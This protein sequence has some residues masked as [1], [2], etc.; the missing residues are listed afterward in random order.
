L[1]NNYPEEKKILIEKSLLELFPKEDN[2]SQ[3]IYKAMRHSLFPGGKRFRPV[4][5]LLTAEIL[6][7]DIRKILPTACATE[8]IHTYSLIHDDLPAIDN[9]NLRRGQPTCHI[10][11]GEDIAILAGDALFAE[12]FYLISSKQ[13]ADCSLKIIEVIKELSFASGV[14]G[15]VGGQVVD[16]EST[17][18]N[19][20]LSTLEFI[21][22][23]K[24]GRLI[25]AS[26][27]VASILA[28]ASEKETEA[29]SDYSDCL[30]LAFQITDDIL[31]T[32]GK[33][34]LLGKETGSDKRLFKSTYVSIFGLEKTKI[35][36]E[37][38]IEKAKA[39][40]DIFG[41]KKQP[42]IDIANFVYNR[43][44]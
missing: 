12:A 40:L 27:K 24:T 6:N 23:N 7:Y 14:R 29:L 11:F 15:M 25:S 42:L 44:S 41:E 17:G 3:T 19:I 28:G 39:S 2:Y 1:K 26:I 43:D 5:S 34:E 37:E 10:V 20:N 22:K 38:A 30:G 4:L 8:Y 36:A 9:D 18:K 32:T 35:Y 21:H 13:E 33:T 31:D 16:I